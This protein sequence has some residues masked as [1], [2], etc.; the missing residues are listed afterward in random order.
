MMAKC[1]SSSSCVPE[2]VHTGHR[3][4]INKDEFSMIFYAATFAISALH[5]RVILVASQV[6]GE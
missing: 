4:V 2:T 5:L 1:D 3:K 6:P